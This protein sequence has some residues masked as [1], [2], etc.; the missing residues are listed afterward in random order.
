[1]REVLGSSLGRAMCSF[2][3]CDIWWPMWEVRARAESSK[4]TVSSVPTW[5]RADSGTNLIK[6][7]EIVTGRPCG[8]VAQWSECS[9]SM[10]EVLGSSPGQAICL[11]L[12]CDIWWPVWVRAR[13]AC[14]KGTVSS[15]PACACAATQNGRI[16]TW[17][18][19]RSSRYM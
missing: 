2:L 13:A 12:P 19:V 3:P 6:Q 18:F 7:G 15:V 9:H 11:F 4:G 8:S 1:M 10:R 17:L 5:F 16:I 14:S